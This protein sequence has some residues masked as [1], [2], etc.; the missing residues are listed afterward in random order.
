MMGSIVFWDTT[1]SI[2]FWDTTTV[3]QPDDG[4]DRVLGH[5]AIGKIIHRRWSVYLSKVLSRYVV[6]V[7]ER[8]TECRVWFCNLLLGR[9]VYRVDNKVSP[10]PEEVTLPGHVA[11][12]VPPPAASDEKGAPIAIEP[13][14]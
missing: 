10:V 9:Y 5:D 1:G 14:S 13:V 7:E 12:T 4:L 11:V 2:V 3:S 8:A 6:A